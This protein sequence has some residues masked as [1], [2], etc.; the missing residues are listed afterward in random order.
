MTVNPSNSVLLSVR[1]ASK[2]YKMG[3]IDVPALREAS[4]DI[5]EGEF[6]IV[7]GPSGS[8]KS[9]LLN[10]I[11]G[12]DRPTQGTL[13]FLGEYLTHYNDRKLTLYRKEQIGFIFQF[14]NLIPTLTA[15]ENVQVAI[16]I[17][18][19][20]MDPMEAIRLVGM[21]DRSDHFPAQLS[22]G[23]QQRVSIA[24]AIA[25]NPRLLLCD[26]PTGALDIVT[27]RQV[28]GLLKRLNREIGKTV[29]LITHNSAIAG[30]GDRIAQLRDGQ[31]AS[32]RENTH[33]TS[34]EE[35]QW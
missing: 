8:G 26:E 5:F 6:L 28:L 18:R 30:I 2:I 21:E 27:S 11:G 25:S 33:P 17:A 19:D 10:L 4:I 23:E 12:M 13:S 32:V 9:T 24:R 35:V 1:S 14:Y 3:E 31:I 16:E 29:V 20:P 22:G 15:V 34:V 7:V